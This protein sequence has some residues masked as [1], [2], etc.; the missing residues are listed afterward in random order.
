MEWHQCN[1]VAK[2]SGL[3]C[4]CM[5][6]DDFTVLVSRGGRCHWAKHVYCV[7]ITFKMTEWVEQQIC[8][9]FCVKLQHSCA[10]T[11]RWF[12]RPQLWAT[13]DWQLYHSKVPTHASRV[14]QSFLSKHHM[15]QVTQPPYSPDL[16]P[17][18]F[19]LFP[20]L[21]SPVKGKRF[22]TTDET[23]EN[24]T[25]AAYGNWENCV[26]SK[27]VYFEGDWGVIVLC[28]VFLVSC[29]FFN[30]YLYVSHY[31]TGYLMDRPRMFCFCYST[32]IPPQ[33]SK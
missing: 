24:T 33:I 8:I 16:A 15:A 18:N 31:M 27:D 25:G 6:Y 14:I 2:E 19:W 13:G 10:E 17:W 30:K 20:K 7:A 1:L 4:T 23:Q 26:R 21:N 32:Q 9:R 22:Q 12:R 3:E 11:I 5:N 28:T 29:I